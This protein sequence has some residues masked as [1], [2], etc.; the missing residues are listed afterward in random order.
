MNFET[1][2]F[3]NLFIEADVDGVRQALHDGAD[4]N[5]QDEDGRTALMLA[6]QFGGKHAARMMRTLLY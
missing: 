6:T 5:K 3:F 4:A 1:D 2:E